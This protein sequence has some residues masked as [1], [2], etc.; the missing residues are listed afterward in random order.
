M[1]VETMAFGQPMNAIVMLIEQIIT[2][3]I[4]G[5]NL[6]GA[7][8]NASVS[9]RMKSSTTNSPRKNGGP[10]RACLT[11]INAISETRDPRYG[12]RPFV[13][14]QEGRDRTA[15]PRLTKHH[16]QSKYPECRSGRPV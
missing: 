8:P 13:I 5:L 9:N 12:S 11:R 10:P 1:S 6:A 7:R 4:R 3:Q 15:L 2:R 16:Q 14:V